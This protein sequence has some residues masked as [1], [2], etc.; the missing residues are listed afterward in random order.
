MALLKI[1]DKDGKIYEVQAFKSDS[2][3]PDLSFNPESENAQS[4]IAVAQAIEG[5]LAAEDITVGEGEPDENTA[6][7]FYF[8]IEND[9]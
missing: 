1:R 3:P 4:G 8:Q 7:R 2:T 9:G 5:L 6:G